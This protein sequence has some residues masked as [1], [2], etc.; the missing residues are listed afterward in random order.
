MQ[1]RSNGEFILTGVLS[2]CIKKVVG[3]DIQAD[4]QKLAIEEHEGGI[5]RQVNR[6]GGNPCTAWSFNE[7]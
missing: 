5:V 3:L 1:R 6:V 7:S 2:I 4:A